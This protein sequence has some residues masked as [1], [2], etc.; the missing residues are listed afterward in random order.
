MACQIISWNIPALWCQDIR[1]ENN[2]CKFCKKNNMDKC[3]DCANNN[4]CTINI[5]VCGCYFHTH[6]IGK[7]LISNDICPIHLNKWI[8][9]EEIIN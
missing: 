1:P 3:V 4:N 5:G 2:V 7:W 9:K 6:C 8:T